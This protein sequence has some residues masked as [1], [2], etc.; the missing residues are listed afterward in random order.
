[1][2]SLHFTPRALPPPK[3]KGEPFLRL[4]PYLDLGSEEAPEEKEYTN[5]KKGI[6][7]WGK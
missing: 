5:L 2:H 1:M 6:Y 7:P 3:G 4:L